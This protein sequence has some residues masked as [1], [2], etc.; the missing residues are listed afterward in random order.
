MT[1]I[2]TDKEYAE[3][4]FMLA[5]EEN[6]AEEY[7]KC[8]GSVEK[9]IDD[10]P[11][12]IDLL[13]SPAIPLEERLQAIDEAFGDFPEHPLSFLKLLCET[14]NIRLLKDCICEYK[15]LYTESSDIVC[16]TV[17]SAVELSTAQKDA[18][19]RK[20]EKQYGKQIDPTYL[21][22]PSLLGGLKV[23]IEG[24]TYDGSVKRR[25]QDIKDV[26]I[27]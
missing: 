8:L 14:G 24:K 25:L 7:L 1:M 18:L 4:L 27:G 11:D 5:A 6:A 20:L 26:I 2:Q 19:C 22:D 10:N 9:V 16:A 15:R 3:A 12:Y 21:I 13:A 17:Y 23:E